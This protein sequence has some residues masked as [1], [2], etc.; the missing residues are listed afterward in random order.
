MEKRPYPG[1]RLQPFVS[2]GL[3]VAA[4]ATFVM[5]SSGDV[6]VQALVGV[7]LASLAFSVAIFPQYTEF[8]GMAGALTSDG[9]VKAKTGKGWGRFF[10]LL[11]LLAVLFAAPLLILFV[12]PQFFL[13]AIV[14][15][16]VGF[17][18]FQIAFT[19][20]IRNWERGKGVIVSRYALVSK[21]DKGRRVVLE[22]GLRAE[23]R[24]LG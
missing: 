23:R 13:G 8:R 2:A 3:L 20:Y 18:G 15:I 19:V 11:S 21:D 17:S 5:F 14:G 4:L 16:I 6:A 10:P 22:Y 24:R 1:S 12:A 7:V 9:V